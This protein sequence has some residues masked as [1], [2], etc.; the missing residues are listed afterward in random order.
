MTEELRAGWIEIRTSELLLEGHYTAIGAANLAIAEWESNNAKS[1][2]TLT[3]E[4][5]RRSERHVELCAKNVEA[6]RRD[7][8]LPGAK[9]KMQDIE[10]E[11]KRVMNDLL[12]NL[13]TGGVFRSDWKQ[14]NWEVTKPA[15]RRNLMDRVKGW[16]L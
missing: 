2:E 1:H 14:P 4:L 6:A 15:P 8:L 9:K 11:E 10:S 16:M 3:A 7:G 5:H 13:F 12:D